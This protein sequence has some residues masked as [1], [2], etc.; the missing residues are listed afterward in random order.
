MNEATY[1]YMK[2]K[3][4]LKESRAQLTSPGGKLS[5]KGEFH[6]LTEVKD[7]KFRFRVIVVQ[8]R[9]GSNLLSRNAAVKMGFIKRCDEVKYNVFGSTGLLKTEPVPIKMKEN[10]SPYCVTTAHRVRFPLKQKVKDELDRMLNDGII[11]E[12]TA[13][14]DWCAPMV[15]VVKPNGKIRITVDFR[16]LNESVK[17]PHCML[18]NLDDIAPKLAGSKVFSTLDASSGF[19]QIPLDEDSKPLTTFITPFGRYSFERVPMG[20]SLGPECFQTKMREVMS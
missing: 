18:P 11:R 14:T 12:Q 8:I 10:A 9:V 7:R 19:F 5:V 15:P 6:A 17:R 20:I 4:Q 13:P 1:Q 3:P 2:R 16:R